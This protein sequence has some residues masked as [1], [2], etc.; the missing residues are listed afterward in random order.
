MPRALT[1]TPLRQKV[2]QFIC[3]FK[4]D[5]DGVSPSVSEIGEGCGISSTSVVRYCL[6]SLERLGMIECAYGKG[7]KSRMI[8]VVGGSWIAPVSKQADR[9]VKLGS[10]SSI[11]E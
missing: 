4:R 3:A 7:N 2:Y 6:D 8:M 1:L 10:S 9:A 5:H 11:T